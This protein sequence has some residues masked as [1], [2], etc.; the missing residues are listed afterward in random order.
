VPVPAA[1]SAGLTLRIKNVRV[2][3][4]DFPDNEISAWFA[5]SEVLVYTAAP[6]VA[7]KAPGV[8][9]ELQSASGQPVQTFSF[10][11][12]ASTAALT[13]R[14]QFREGFS[15]SFRKRNTATSVATPAALADQPSAV[16]DYHTETGYYN[17]TLDATYHLD[18]AGLATQGTRLV[19]RFNVPAGTSVY[20]TTAPLPNTGATSAVL[21]TTDANGAGAFHAVAA[22]GTVDVGGTAV[23]IAPVSLVNGAGT[24][25]WEI[26]DADPAALESYTF[27]II[28]V[29]G[30]AGTGGV[31]A[32]LGPISDTPVGYRVAPV[33]RFGDTTADVQR[34]AASPCLATTPSAI[35]LSYQTGAPAPAPIVL[36]VA[37]TGTPL[38]ITVSVVSSPDGYLSVSPTSGVT[39]ADLQITFNPTNLPPN[40]YQASIVLTAGGQSVAIP[41]V[42]DVSLGPS[43]IVPFSCKANVP[44]PT[45]SRMDGIAE[46]VGDI[47]LICDHG[48]P[49]A[50]GAPVPAMDIKVTLST[51]ATGR[52]YPNGWSEALL[53][54]DEPGASWYPAFPQVACADASGTCA[55]TGTGDGIHTY[56]GTAGRPNIFLG[57]IS[58]N[59]VTFPKVP[60]DPAGPGGFA[61]APTPIRIFRIVN[62]RGDAT[63]VQV[64]LGAGYITAT[65][66][67]GTVAVPYVLGTASNVFPALTFS[68]RTPDNSAA[69]GGSANNTAQS[70]APQRSGVLRFAEGFAS[71]FRTRTDASFVNADTSPPPDAM[72]MPSY[73]YAAETS[74]YSPGLTSPVV[75]FTAVGLA[76]FATRLKAHIDN[77]PAGA[78]VF[79]STRNIAVNTNVVTVPA[80]GLV[81]RLIAAEAGPFT[82]AVATTT[83]ES[84]A[85]AELTPTNGSA[86]AVWELLRRGDAVPQ[87]ADFAVWVQANAASATPATVT[88][89]LAPGPAAT[90][91]EPR[92]SA[93]GTPQ[94]LFSVICPAQLGVAKSHSGNL[95][96]GQTGATYA[97]TVSNTSGSCPSAGAVTVTE[98]LPTGLTLV[99][100]SGQ[101]WTCPADGTICTRSDVLAPGASY[102]SITVT[103]N[104]AAT[105][106]ASVA[107]SVTVSGGGSPSSTATDP[108]TVIPVAGLTVS[109]TP[110]G[111][112][113]VVDGV[114]ITTPQT[115][116]WAA[117]STH[118]VAAGA[119]QGSA[120]TQYVF[121]SWS[122][123]GV[124]SH[125]VTATGST[126]TLTANF[127]TQY[128]LTLTVA[129]AASGI[130]VPTPAS[131][132]GYYDAGTTVSVLAT[133]SGG[134]GFWLY[135]GDLAGNHN[136]QTVTMSAPKS[137]TANFAAPPTAVSVTPA[138]GTGAAQTFS[139]VYTTPK[140]YADLQWVQMLFAVAT[141]GGG[142]AFCFVH[143]DVPGNGFWLYGD[144]GFFIGPVTPGTAT[145]R[146]QNSLCALN[147]AGSTVTGSGSTLTVNPNV[148]FKQG[149]ARN[150]YMRALNFGQAD[151]GWVSKGTWT[152][153]AAGQGTLSVTPSSGAGSTQTFTAT[154][155]DPPGFA[156]AAFGWV[157]FLVAAAS[158]GGGQPFC[159]VH[160]DRGGNGLWMYSGDVG[161]FVG[162]VTP[163]TASN[164]LNSSACSV[165]TAGAV[166][167][168]T[169]GN[170]VVS[171]PVTM[172]APMSGAKKTFQ[173]TLDTLNRD[174][175]WQ[176]TG[177][178]TVQ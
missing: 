80:N 89:T 12:A 11:Q 102:G 43:G 40:V 93:N 153:T 130:L 111:R 28:V 90:T 27:G 64:R 65:V 34:C 147:T 33:P 4:R 39:P 23:G 169:G 134:N 178:W 21:T 50:A 45:Q 26:L 173:R 95:T 121:N 96:Q 49:T 110:P 142:Q 46:V 17:S 84:I 8:V 57:K 55:I 148:T 67:A 48:T 62:L 86:T 108:A 85:A 140:G 120:G 152:P 68:V 161:F 22:T 171:V 30:Q 79:V 1:S 168:N 113:V 150:L 58:G 76:D 56:D 162:P 19:A 163:G 149:G 123:S 78:R 155:P 109:S 70:A 16:Q 166:V 53:M 119:Q 106:A 38:N 154:Y 131:S 105:A 54:V 112:S 66:S 104:V 42:V 87:N 13:H 172:K 143:Y 132:S 9:S 24:A 72:N 25:A 146:L 10:A 129:P 122:D 14:L 137:V 32:G 139:A 44:N 118:A 2:N 47:V 73:V 75:D 81:A 160:Y 71:A 136:P 117:G 151:T 115:F 6:V 164:A 144:R 177:T 63:S 128:L 92:F 107:N 103:V 51:A 145:N 77:I 94:N 174:T 100:M 74:F 91:V 99:S 18:Q 98:S 165:N 156:G 135:T 125:T 3:A 61:F 141:D 133:P 59:V 101:G 69:S 37:S 15:D 31:I 88:G 7:I 159:F 36:H 158:D 126:A 41:V 5:S 124:A 60:M 29:S 114:S 97:V 157:Q 167:T 116:Q 83:I 127:T 20:V 138:S 52:T 35:S 175:G 176:Q 170:L 82:P